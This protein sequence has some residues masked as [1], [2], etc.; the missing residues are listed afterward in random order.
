MAQR[1]FTQSELNALC[2]PGEAR[3]HAALGRGD[4]MHA[5]AVYEDV[6]KAFREF[7]DIYIK[8]V[9]TIL[10]FLES[11][12]NVAATLGRWDTTAFHSSEHVARHAI[13]RL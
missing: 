1:L 9:A 12:Y 8:W 3:F 11:T 5:K 2:L 13:D 4:K 6:E 10:E 7:H